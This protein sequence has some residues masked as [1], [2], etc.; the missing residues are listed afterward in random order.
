MSQHIAPSGCEY[1]DCRADA[2]RGS[3]FCFAHNPITRIVIKNTA[4]WRALNG[5]TSP[6]EQRALLEIAFPKETP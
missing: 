4:L 3:R 6:N 2:E 5:T 1:G